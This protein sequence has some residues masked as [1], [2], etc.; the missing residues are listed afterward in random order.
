MKTDKPIIT[1]LMLSYNSPSLE[2]AVDSVLA[3]DYENI[4]L[5][6]VDD[7][8]ER[9]DEFSLREYISSKSSGNITELVIVRNPQNKGITASSNE[10]LRRASGKYI[11][12]LAGDDAFYDDKVVSDLYNEFE[13]TGAM[14]I[15]GYRE[16]YDCKLEL[17]QRIEPEQKY[18]DMISSLSPSELFCAMEGFNFVFGC[19]MARSAEC[20]QKFGF[21]DEQ[22]R[23]LDDYSMNMKL[24]RNGV[25]FHFVDRVLIKYRGGGIS[26]LSK[27]DSRYFEE[28]DQL[29]RNEIEPYSAD[30]EK[31][32]KKYKRWKTDTRDRKNY[33][34]KLNSCCF[35]SKPLIMAQYIVIRSFRHIVRMF[36]R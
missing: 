16:V 34:Y 33:E 12:N 2:T 32:R 9:F 19:C 24:L 35:M 6:I 22:Y 7:Y 11:V 14:I 28:S 13:K 15:T 3:Q 29:F 21:Y 26:S 10:A 23:F 5:I 17:P 27:I 36:G 20:V 30:P 8:S 4:Q 25:K 18:A 31:A 1:V